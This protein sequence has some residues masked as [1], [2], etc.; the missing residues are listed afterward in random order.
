M[1]KLPAFL[2][3]IAALASTP[4]VQAADL[5]R[6]PPV[7]ARYHRHKGQWRGPVFGGLVS[8]VRGATP[9]TVPFFAYGWYPGL[10]YYAG[11]RHS[12]CCAAAEPVISVNY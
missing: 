1:T 10:A 5:G 8:G 3:A 9:L 12:V 2:V 7:A 11:W 6:E 4:T